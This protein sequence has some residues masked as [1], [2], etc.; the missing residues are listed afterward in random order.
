M[1]KIKAICRDENDYKRRSNSEIEKVFR[2][3]NPSFHP[4]SKE[5]EYI[6]ALNAVKLEKAFAK[7]FLSSLNEHTD[8][9]KCMSKNKTNLSEI[10]SGG[11]DGQ[12]IL[13]N[14]IEKKPIFNINSSHNFVKGV[15]FSNTGENFL[16]CGDDNTINI[17]NKNSMYIHKEK[18]LH[19]DNKT[20]KF[21]NFIIESSGASCYKP[22]SVYHI[23]SSLENIDHSYNDSIFSTAGQFVSIWNY[24]RQTPINTFRNSTDGFLRVKFNP[25]ENNIL[26]ATGYDRSINIYDLRTNNP[27][28]CVSLKNKSSAACWNPQE[29]FNFTVGNEDSNCY[30]FDMRKLETVKMIHKDHILA[31]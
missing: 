31:V 27:L 1:V 23:N 21:N 12:V 20:N 15:C 6:R 26:L 10:V 28:K 25:V 2:N 30:S 3:V 18:R 16:T 24:E 5:K 8:G 13:W 29:P 17:W 7:P 14:V 9:I 4:F 11:F 19:M 22:I